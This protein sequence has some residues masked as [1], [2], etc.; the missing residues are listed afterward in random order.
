VQEGKAAKRKRRHAGMKETARRRITVK[1]SLKTISTD[2]LG[3][4]WGEG[5]EALLRPPHP[6]LKQ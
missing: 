3:I 2:Q 6:F 5:G 4:G 1:S